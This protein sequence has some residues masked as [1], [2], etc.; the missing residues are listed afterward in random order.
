M[1]RQIQISE[2]EQCLSV[3]RESF[4][5]V[6]NEFNWTEE[7]CPH[8]PTFMKIEKLQNNWDNGY[9]MYGYYLNDDIIGYVSLSKVGDTMY[10]LHKLAILPEYRHNNYGKQL[11]DFCINKA[12]ELG[13]NKIVLDI[14]EENTKLKNWYAAKGFVHTGV[15][16][17]NVFPFTIGYMELKI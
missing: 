5:T 1:I 9:L 14:I 17:F 12:K 8:H 10:E 2:L 3:I 6:A 4:A 7:N 11:L 13:G 15:K 16:K